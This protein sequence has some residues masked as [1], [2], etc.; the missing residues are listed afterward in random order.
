[1]GSDKCLDLKSMEQNA[2]FIL[3]IES[4]HQKDLNLTSLNVRLRFEGI[5]LQLNYRD[6]QHRFNN[7]DRP[8]WFSSHKKDLT[9]YKVRKLV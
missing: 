3:V 6:G 4:H 5:S 2:M 9:Y 7:S 8:S 1:M